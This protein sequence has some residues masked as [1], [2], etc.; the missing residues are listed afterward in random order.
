MDTQD[1]SRREKLRGL[2]KVAT[3][4]PLLTVAII[5]ASVVTAMLE[6]IGISFIIPIVEIVQS[7]GDPAADASGEV[8]V[9]VAVF[10]FL[11]IPFELGTVVLGV[12]A[13]M[14]VRFAT[15]FLVEW[16]R[17]ALQTQYVRYLQTEAFE[18]ALDAEVAYFDE[19][20][21]DD[22]LNA[23]V[24]QAE[25][26]GNVI[27]DTIKF[28]KELLLS[29]VYLGIALY[30][31]PTLTLAAAVLLGGLT[32]FVRKIVEPGYT[33][34]DRVAQ[35]NEEIQRSVQAG[36][37]GIRDVKLF[38]L[39]DELLERFSTHIETYTESSI[40][41]GRNEALIDNVYN[42][43]AAAMV[44][45]LIYVAIGFTGLSLAALGMFLFAM[46]QLAPRLSQAN[47]YFY[48]VEG[49]FPHLIRTQN[50]VE[51]LER[52]EEP[53]GGD[54]PVPDSPF[55]ITFDDVS[56]AYDEEPVL[57]D[58]SFRIDS[59][60]FVAFVGAS[61]AGKSTAAVL[62][63][64]L[65]DPD[66]GQITVAG[67]PLEEY[68]LTEWRSRVAVVRQ[69][70]FLFNDT[71]RHNVT[72]GNRDATQSEIERACEIAHVNEFLDEL[73]EGYDT[74]L[75]DDG[76]RLSGGQRQ[77][78]ALAR[79]LL[80]DADLLILDE[81]TSDLDSGIEDRVHTAIEE[82][83]RDYAIL[84][85]AH[86]LSTVRGADRIHTLED[87]RIIEQGDHG[88]LLEEDGRYA[89]LYAMQ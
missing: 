85:I 88:E 23:I 8:A 2:Y 72:I 28:S 51:E 87:G 7:P 56:F 43:T 57:R 42:F 9:F 34:G 63:A 21:S 50:F 86:R 75:G 35:A 58:V 26:A 68:D 32:L 17:I 16:L 55:P 71:L 77:R 76:V 30:L 61:G 27:R 24:T 18:N 10:E 39:S 41:L 83:D 67:R 1:L 19:E 82:M 14:A 13:I 38:T 62:L 3:F 45:G 64:R 73:P 20:G 48:R 25:H 80:K 47:N 70:P 40:K 31:A 65:Y 81:A 22:I 69:K 12:I 4:R 29:G 79:A 53:T 59:N 37:Q 60:E 78:V 66:S 15:T 44:F 33:I 6:G 74:E 46:F 5:L 52:R 89:D 84:A 54:R 49:R 36:T 11:G